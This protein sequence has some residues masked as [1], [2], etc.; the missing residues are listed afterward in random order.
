M[1]RVSIRPRTVHDT[2]E[3]T[4]APHHLR[5]AAGDR[6]VT[7]GVGAPVVNRVPR[8]HPAAGAGLHVTGQDDVGDEL[9]VLIDPGV[10]QVELG[11]GEQQLAPPLVRGS[12]RHAYGLGRSVASDTSSI[13]A[14]RV[15]TKHPQ[16]GHPLPRGRPT[17]D[18]LAREV[19]ISGSPSRDTRRNEEKPRVH[20]REFPRWTGEC[21]PSRLEPLAPGIRRPGAAPADRRG[22]RSGRTEAQ[23]PRTALKIDTQPV[24]RFLPSERRAARGTYRVH[25]R[26]HARTV[27]L[28]ETAGSERSTSARRQAAGKPV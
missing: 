12:V 28:R 23:P 11:Q 1:N 19:E 22:S 25:A 26:V 18:R 5:G 7:D 10:G 6:E 24:K 13:E 2:R 4:L 3:Q 15:L 27:I 17:I 20:A 21:G 9:V 8:D 14:V 16:P